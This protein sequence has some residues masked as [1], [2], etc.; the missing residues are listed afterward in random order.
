MVSSSNNTLIQN[1]IVGDKLSKRAPLLADEIRTLQ[2]E[3]QKEI[4]RIRIDS[5]EIREKTIHFRDQVLTRHRTQALSLLTY[6]RRAKMKY[7]RCLPII[8]PCLVPAIVMDNLASLCRAL[9]FPLLGIP[10]GF[11][12]INDYKHADR[13]SVTAT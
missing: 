4:Q 6:L 10:K 3:L 12:D 9:C 5:F 11:S 1:T 2:R 8:W 13:S 7:I